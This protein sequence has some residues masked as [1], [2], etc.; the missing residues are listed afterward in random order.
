MEYH[1]R[2]S[3]LAF[4]NRRAILLFA[5]TAFC[6]AALQDSST[7]R[8]KDF[9][10]FCS[11]FFV[12]QKPIQNCFFFAKRRGRL[13]TKRNHA[14]QLLSKYGACPLSTYI[15]LMRVVCSAHAQQ[16]KILCI[17]MPFHSKQSSPYTACILSHFAKQIFVTVSILSA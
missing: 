9:H 14:A 7:A 16:S 4:F 6:S 12:V 1:E 13:F 11:K 15:T 17:A 2:T 8:P 3:R 10:F 5:C